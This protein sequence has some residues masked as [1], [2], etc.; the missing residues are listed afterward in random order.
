MS[1]IV[2]GDDSKSPTTLTKGEGKNESTFVIS[3]DAAIKAAIVDPGKTKILAGPVTVDLLATGTDLAKS[4]VILE[5]SKTETEAINK[6]YEG[7]TLV[8]IQIDDPD[9]DTCWAEVTLVRGLID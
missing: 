9:R 6:E 1:I 8:E 7:D 3:A 5:F 2:L 4:L